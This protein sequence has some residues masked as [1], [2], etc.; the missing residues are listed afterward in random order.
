MRKTK[1]ICTIGP[2]TESYEMLEKLAEAGMSVARLN[3][4]HGSHESHAEVIKR[5]QTLNTKLKYPVAILLDTQGPEIRTGERDSNLNL[6]KGD[7]ISVVARS[8]EDVEENSLMVNYENLITDMQVGDRLTV[9]NGLINLEILEKDQ[10]V[11]RCEV[12]DGGVLKSKRHV[13]LP[14]IRVN[15]PAITDKDR[16]DILF[17]LSMD[18]DFI[19]LSFVR[20]ADDIA[21]L[22]QLMD[23]KKDK[24]K[25]IAKIEDQE[26]VRN[27]DDIIDIA[28]G[29]M[30]ARGDLGCEVDFWEL[31]NIQ[32][33]IVRKCAQK[34]KRVIVATH[35]LESM[36]ENPMPTRAEVTDVA[37]A[38]YEEADCIM[39]SG[40]TTVG[41]YPIKCVENMS[42]IATSIERHRGLRFTDD[43]L[44]DNPKQN[45][46]ASAVHLAESLPAKAIVVITRRGRMANYVTNCHPILPSIHAFTND[47]RTRRQLGLNRNVYAHKLQF[48]NDPEKTLSKAFN[49]LL[50]EEG[51]HEGDQV[52]VISDALG[53][54]GSGLDAIQVRELKVSQD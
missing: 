34:G 16:S 48:S 33:R 27:I 30:V 21:Q 4:S 51:F 35:L 5:I 14:G 26:G 28:D 40:E 7:I 37:N 24:V 22:H 49:T 12:V 1:I 20:E 15:L 31:P 42:R 13:N 39:L 47:G 3:M 17:G 25:V 44:T 18:V 36:I 9:D 50:E 23:E 41:K 8:S 43:L 53:V 29:I 11:M 19:A 10:R 46:A 45:L 6:K 2:A 54:S 32:R 52:V 38:V